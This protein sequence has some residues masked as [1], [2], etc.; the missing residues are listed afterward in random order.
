MKSKKHALCEAAYLFYYASDTA[1]EEGAD[2]SGK[3]RRRLIDLIGDALIIAY[4]VN[5]SALDDASGALM[6]WVF[7]G[8]V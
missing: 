1:F 2:T 4:K 3:L 6:Y 5:L 8:Q 7:V